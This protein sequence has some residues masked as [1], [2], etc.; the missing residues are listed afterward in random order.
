M[1]CMLCGTENRTEAQRCKGCGALLDSK[2]DIPIGRPPRP[3]VLEGAGS[4]PDG[5]AAVASSGRRTRVA[6]T[7]EIAQAAAAA[8]GPPPAAPGAVRSRKTVYVAPDAAKSEGQPE[9]TLPRVIGFLVTYTWNP[10]GQYFPIREGKNLFGSQ[11]GIDGSLPQDSAMSGQHFA[12]MV[13][14]G[15]IRVRDLDSTNATVVDGEEIW[16]DSIGAD[17]G[18]KIEAGKSVLTLVRVPGLE[19]LSESE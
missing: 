3:T 18:S 13:R 9:Q 4:L 17:H 5:Q 2:K 1:K 14:R 8:A 19:E 6:S 11:A 16:G 12:V 15:K 10:S 7:D